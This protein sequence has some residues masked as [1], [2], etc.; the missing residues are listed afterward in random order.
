MLEKTPA[1]LQ[2]RMIQSVGGTSG[3]TV[4]LGLPSQATPLPLRAAEAA[5]PAAEIGEGGEAPSEAQ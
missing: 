2:L 3:N 1:L 5:P 4:V